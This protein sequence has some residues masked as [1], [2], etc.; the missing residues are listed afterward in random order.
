MPSIP[1]SVSSRVDLSLVEPADT[2]P[3]QAELRYDSS[4]PFAVALLL[5]AD[6]PAEEVIEWVFSR[7]LLASGLSKSSGRGDV[8]IEPADGH[9]VHIELSSPSG[10]AV[11]SINRD[12]VVS[13]LT[14]TCLLV[15][16]GTESDHLDLDAELRQLLL[17]HP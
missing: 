7:S 14:Q 1:D 6:L 10:R 13:F 3:L 4:D 5:G 15:A 12:V 8:R 9:T 16:P 11:L 2:L 17:S